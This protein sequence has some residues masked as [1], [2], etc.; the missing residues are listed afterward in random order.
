VQKYGGQPI[1]LAVM[2]FEQRFKFPMICHT[3]IIHTKNDL[4][5]PK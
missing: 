2:L 3:L 5:N 4:L 1:H